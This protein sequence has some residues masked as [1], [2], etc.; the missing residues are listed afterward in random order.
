MYIKRNQAAVHVDSSYGP[1]AT[2]NHELD[3][4]IDM[5]AI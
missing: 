1:T 4:K 5:P 3:R 2:L